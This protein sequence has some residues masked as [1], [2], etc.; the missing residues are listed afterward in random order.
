MKKYLALIILS[1]Y[2]FS[3]ISVYAAEKFTVHLQIKNGDLIPA[4][5]EVPTK[6]IIRIKISNIGNQPAEFES[7]QLRKEKV[8]APGA[9]SVVVIAPL[10]QGTYTF[11]DDFHLDHPKGKIIAKESSQ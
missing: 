6:K 4:V 3:P 10:R 8:L 9:S 11:F 5:L 1:F 7:T 2:L